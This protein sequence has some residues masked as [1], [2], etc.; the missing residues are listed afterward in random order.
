[1]SRL[2][3]DDG[4]EIHWEQRSEAAGP[5]VVISP[6]ANGHPTVFEPLISDLG[7]DHRLISYDARGYG[8]ST[9]TGP[10]DMETGAADLAAVA[11]AAGGGAV[12]IGLA[13]ASSRGVR[14]AARRPDLVSAVV[15]PGTAPVGI[16]L[17]G[18]SDTL[19]ASESVI[20]ALF[21]QLATDY[22]G[23]VRALMTATNPQ[24]SEDEVRDRVN[25]QEEYAPQEAVLGRLRA[26]AED[27]ATEFSRQ[28][29]DRLWLLRSDQIAGPWFPAGDEMHRLIEPV[30]PKAH[31]EKIADGIVSRPDL[32]AEIVRRITVPDRTRQRASG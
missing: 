25:A 20:D 7:S 14:V 27:D 32:T 19:V 30:L 11:E 16:G 10:H 18:Q 31:H 23:A 17:L 29:G 12:V 26:W 24:M 15:G 8:R 22:R 21:E 13:D 28:I 2:T 3:R 4:V 1:V 5:L 6:H 9:R